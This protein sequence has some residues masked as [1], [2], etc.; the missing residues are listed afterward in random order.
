MTEP[1]LDPITRTARLVR[2]QAVGCAAL[3]SPLYGALL[4][5]AADDLLRGGPTAELLAEHLLDP[6]PSALA[7][8]MMGGVHALVL[9]GQAPRLAAY[10]PSA[11][12]EA[13]TADRIDAAW[14][15]MAEL[16]ATARLAI[17]EWLER[18]PQTN[19]VGRAAALVGG[20]RQV[21]AEAALPVRL[22]EIGASA[23]LNLRADCFRID[24][25]AGEH[26][27]AA[28]E[29]VLPDAWQGRPVPAGDLEVVSRSGGD[30]TPID[31]TTADGER[32]L[33][34]YLWADQVERLQRLRGA[35]RISRRVPAELREEPA[36]TTVERTEL[37]TGTWTVVWHSVFRQYL[38]ASDQAALDAALHEL[39]GRATGS[40]RFAHLWLEPERRPGGHYREFLVGLTTWPG[41]RRRIIGTAAPH[42]V[43]TVWEQPVDF[44]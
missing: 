9:A 22:V 3:G 4:E 5:Q 21:L 1:A 30:L 38:D 37:M 8:R 10:F 25:E 16:L 39:G 23:G 35:I 29:V 28:A 14:A 43:P 32:R 11:G 40:Q 15:A 26:G 44:P 42:G 2:E 18:P 17:Q 31:P 19:E 6:G 41:G 12:G 36:T 27:H 34:A 33:T 13:P 20:L 24:G 7:L